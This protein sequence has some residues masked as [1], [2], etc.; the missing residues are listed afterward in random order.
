MFS[1]VGCL[2]LPNNPA[3]QLL[4][5]QKVKSHKAK[6]QNS[7]A[8]DLIACNRLPKAQSGRILS[9]HLALR[10]EFCECL[11]PLFYQ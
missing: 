7:L 10:A 2:L 4:L 9:G 8:V 5:M 1:A 6:T 11:K 3:G